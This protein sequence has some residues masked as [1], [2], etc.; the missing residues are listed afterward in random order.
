[1]PS[2]KPSLTKE[3]RQHLRGLM[4]EVMGML[5]L[6]LSMQVK[7]R[8]FMLICHRSRKT[9][10]GEL[11]AI[12]HELWLPDSNSRDGEEEGDVLGDCGVEG[13]VVE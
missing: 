2:T 6:A 7:L 3:Q 8:S 5:L 13:G 1:M 12:S 11:V 9:S 4:K 10:D